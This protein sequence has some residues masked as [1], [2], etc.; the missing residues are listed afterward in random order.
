MTDTHTA[1]GSIVVLE[2]RFRL[3][4]FNDLRASTSALCLIKGLIPRVGL[5]VA[6]GP[7]KS[8]K[9]FVIF[10]AMIH[11]AL[12]WPYRGRRVVQGPVVYAAFEGAD[13]YGRRAEA[14]RRH[15]RLDDEVSVPFFLVPARMDFIRDHALLIAAIRLEL[16]K[17]APVAVVLDTLNRSLAGSESS[18]EDM[19]NYVRAADAV[20]E[21]FGCAVVVVHHCGIDGSRPR[22]HTSLTG[23][24]DAQLAVKRDA[25]NNV[26]LTVE[27]LKDGAEGDVIASHLEAVEIGADEDGN[28]VTSCAVVP[29]EPAYAD[30]KT[31][32]KV[33]PVPRVAFDQLLECLAD[34]GAAAPPSD[35]IPAGV[36]TV[37]L[38]EWKERLSKVGI[39]N[40]EGNPREQF[41]RIRVTLQTARAIGVWEDFV[42]AVT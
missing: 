31:G 11:V 17:A 29:A 16:G 24:V 38:S 2:P 23:A 5:T 39:I 12:G 42:W 28:P 7:P 34:S 37:T 19:A 3:I 10:D 26:L 40:A 18:D 20:R 35:R 41:R 22:G 36:K 6:W 1:G 15:H 21:T 25:A 9:S 32:L 27:W 8:G 30:R 13:G 4:Q 33:S 14:F